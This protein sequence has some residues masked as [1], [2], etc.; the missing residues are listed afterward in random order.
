M[1][2]VPK[3]ILVLGVISFWLGTI[4]GCGE[5]QDSLK[6]VVSGVSQVNEDKAVAGDVQ[7]GLE[8]GHCPNRSW[9]FER[10][11]QFS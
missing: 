3:A 10:P 11:L 1:K 6:E 8:Q 2:I 9:R 4:S 5:K 7:S